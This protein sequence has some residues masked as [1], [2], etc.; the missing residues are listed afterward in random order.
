MINTSRDRLGWR[1]SP[2][3]PPHRPTH[4]MEFREKKENITFWD[5]FF[6][7]GFFHS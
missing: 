1:I 2:A 5:K 6:K 7:G 4:L 3:S